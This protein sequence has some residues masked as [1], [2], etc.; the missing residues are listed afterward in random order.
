MKKFFLNNWFS[1]IKGKFYTINLKEKFIILQ[2]SE[3]LIKLKNKWGY[4]E[5]LRTKTNLL[6]S[7]NNH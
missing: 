6:K 5:V 7:K 1:K 3:F 4:E 2:T